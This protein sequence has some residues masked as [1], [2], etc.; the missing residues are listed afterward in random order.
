MINEDVFAFKKGES[1]L[2]II[3]KQPSPATE[4]AALTA[5]WRE[6]FLLHPGRLE[7][8]I[9]L[10]SDDCC[11]CCSVEK[12]HNTLTTTHGTS[13]KTTMTMKVE[14]VTYTHTHTHTQKHRW[15]GQGMVNEFPTRWLFS[16]CHFLAFSS[17]LGGG[18][19]FRHTMWN[20]WE[21]EITE[22]DVWFVCMHGSV[23]WKLEMGRR[24]Y[25][26]G[27]H[28]LCWLDPLWF[29]LPTH[30][31]KRKSLQSKM[32]VNKPQN[33]HKLRK[34]IFF[35]SGYCYQANHIYISD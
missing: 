18:Q 8:V 3:I 4:E 24:S 7:H 35:N 34:Y 6:L 20:T 15:W 31:Q 29:G 2:I 9:A 10:L 16:F 21:N 27:L 12:I 19:C 32:G 11:C 28:P 5:K 30:P 17:L 1:Y 22:T 23:D 14:H 25:R 33:T 26:R 13:E